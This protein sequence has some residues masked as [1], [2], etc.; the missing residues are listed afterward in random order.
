MNNQINNITP[1]IHNTH[2]HT[3]T[4]DYVF[5]DMSYKSDAIPEECFR[6]SY[7]YPNIKLYISTNDTK[8]LA[9][10]SNIC[11]HI[12]RMQIIKN[13][14]LEKMEKIKKNNLI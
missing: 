9:L 7:E 12:E 1:D 14:H 6:M 3:H 11:E 13:T 5:D 2:T 4:I 10:I 8:N